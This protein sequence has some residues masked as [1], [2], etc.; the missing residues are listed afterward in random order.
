MKPRIIQCIEVA[1]GPVRHYFTADGERIGMLGG[2]PQPVI[3]DA[4]ERPAEDEPRRPARADRT[5]AA[6]IRP[7]VPGVARGGE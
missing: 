3:V 1:I 4:P 7:G 2:E 6:S 5:A